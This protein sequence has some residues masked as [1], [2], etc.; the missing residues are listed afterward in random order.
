MTNAGNTGVGLC[1]SLLADALSGDGEDDDEG[2]MC[3]CNGRSSL[4]VFLLFLCFPVG[5]CFG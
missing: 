2:V 5:C 1:L 4:Y 3:W